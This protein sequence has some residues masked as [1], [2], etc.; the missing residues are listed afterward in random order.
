MPTLSPRRRRSEVGPGPAPW[1]VRAGWWIAATMA[2]C[3]STRCRSSRT[4]GMPG[5]HSKRCSSSRTSSSRSPV[6]EAHGWS[7]RDLMAH[8]VAWQ[9][10]ALDIAKELAVSESSPTAARVE[11]DWDARGG[12]VVNAEIQAQWAARPLAD[13]RDEFSQVA[14]E[15]RGFLTVVPES[16]WIKNADVPADLHRGDPGP[17]RG[18]PRRPRGDPRGGRPMT[19]EPA[20]RPWRNRRADRSDR[21]RPGGGGSSAIAAAGLSGPSAGSSSRPSSGDRAEF[22]LARPVVAAALR[23]P[24]TAASDRGPDWVAFAP[25]RARRSRDRPGGGVARERLA[26]SRRRGLSAP[27]MEQRRGPPREV[28]FPAAGRRAAVVLIAPRRPTI[29]AS[30]ADAHHRRA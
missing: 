6:S 14:G 22:R 25:Q 8:L 3:T 13:V 5:V 27:D 9:L 24:D 21:C 26:A 10:V 15:L 29:A 19:S 4:S 1:T 30:R 2:A 18:A 17:L 20:G 16:R 11:A 7:G 12:E 23:T 28:A